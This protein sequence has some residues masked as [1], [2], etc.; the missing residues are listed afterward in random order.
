VTLGVRQLFDAKGDILTIKANDRVRCDQL[1]QLPTKSR[2]SATIG[3]QYCLVELLSPWLVLNV[4]A[5]VF[6]GPVSFHPAQCCPV[7]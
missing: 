4:A 1:R 7:V 6:I 2:M 5:R 3:L